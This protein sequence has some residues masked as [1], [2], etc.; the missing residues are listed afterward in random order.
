MTSPDDP[1]HEQW[2]P[3]P[4]AQPQWRPPPA[5]PPQWTPPP[6]QPPQWT[7]PPAQPP[8]WTPPPTQQPTQPPPRWN[9][10]PTQQLP[11]V[12]NAPPGQWQTP[13]Y[14]VPAPPQPVRPRRRR[15]LL[16]AGALAT[17]GAVVTGGLAWSQWA[18][19]HSP[20]TVVKGFYRALADGDA[21]AALAFAET[22]PSG[23]Y[24]TSTVLQQQ[25]RVA[26]LADVSIA[27][28]DKSSSTA[29]V[30]VQYRLGFADKPQDVTDQVQLTKHGSSWRLAQVSSTVTLAQV[31]QGADRVTLAGRPLSSGRV[32]LFPGAVPVATDTTAVQVTGHPEVR[33]HAASDIVQINVE[34]SADRK[35][36]VAAALDAAV[37]KCLDAAS[38]DAQCP[39]PTDVTR[40]VPGSLHGTASKKLADGGATVSLSPDGKGLLDVTADLPVDATWKAWDFNNLAVPDQGSI[41]LH[42][43]ATATVDDPNTIYWA[44]KQ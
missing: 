36:Q 33:L 44:G 42:L 25:L 12:W 3:P 10:Q 43:E 4:V 41:T 38:T 31:R 7:P 6:A 23:E 14:A 13:A 8:Q 32:E 19:S 35:K 22:A 30:E 26:K 15:G 18:D 21:S 40:P 24:L 34:V 20:A 37:A 29:T 39:L 16:A 17:V 9:P 5:Q 2:T 28:T 11:P 27:G 1:N